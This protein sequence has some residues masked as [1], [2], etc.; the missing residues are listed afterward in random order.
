ML[1]ARRVAQRPPDDEHP[2]GHTRAEA[3]AAT[4]LAVV[5][6]P[7]ALTIG[8]TAVRRMATIHEMPPTRTRW[9]AG[10]NALIKEALYQYKIRVAR[11]LGSVAVMANAWDQQRCAVLAGGPGRPGDR[12]LGRAGPDL[13]R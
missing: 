11:R 1:F 9:I 13:G 8:W 4:N 10:G 7:S 3:I 2:Y 5:I 12:T 6:I